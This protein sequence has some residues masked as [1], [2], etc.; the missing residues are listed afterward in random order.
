MSDLID[1]IGVLGGIDEHLVEHP[2]LVPEVS[3]LLCPYQYGALGWFRE[4]KTWVADRPE[5]REDPAEIPGI[6]ESLARLAIGDDDEGIEPDLGLR[7]LALTVLGRTMHRY[8]PDGAD[9]ELVVAA[10]T[11]AGL[12]DGDADRADALLRLLTDTSE[13]PGASA[14]DRMLGVAY[15]RNLIS[16]SALQPLRCRGT[17]V[18]VD[19]AGAP[20]PATAVTT[21]LTDSTM[22]FAEAT[23]FLDPGE[24]PRCCPAWCAMKRIGDPVN[25]V[26]HYEEK[27]GI[28]CPDLVLL[29]TCLKFRRVSSQDNRTA[30]LAY[31]LSPPPNPRDCGSDGEVL[32]DEGSIEVRD[33]HP[34]PGIRV[35]TTKRVL[36]RSV[37]PGPLAMFSCVL[38]YGDLGDLL[39]Y[40]CARRHPDKKKP[41]KAK[42]FPAPP[43]GGSGPGSGSDDPF[44]DAA[45]AARK[46][47]AECA[48]SYRASMKKLA[49]GEYTSEDAV[50]DMAGMWKRAAADMATAVDLGVRAAGMTRP[51]DPSGGAKGAGS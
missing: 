25:G 17:V 42:K 47:V 18:E 9:A 41:K 13:Y 48:T 12:S 26:T 16:A 29:S 20:H 43:K 35:T 45:A 33:L 3:E 34:D 22:T 19:V 46:C 36:F 44:G 5:L 40:E 11:C 21:D 32:V 38:G 27:I 6:D 31:R 28:S 1:L 7:L 2:E 8:G 30:V 24:W 50:A 39:V 4:F 14:W 15:A 51:E 49:K 10:L 23:A 37:P